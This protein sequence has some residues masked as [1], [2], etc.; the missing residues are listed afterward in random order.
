MTVITPSN[1]SRKIRQHRSDKNGHSNVEVETKIST[2]WKTQRKS[3]SHTTTSN[4]RQ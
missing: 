1:K 3:H 4:L 2:D